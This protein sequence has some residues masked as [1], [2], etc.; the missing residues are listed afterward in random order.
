M[1]CTEKLRNKRIMELKNPPLCKTFGLD[2]L[3]LQTCANGTQA[4]TDFERY[5]V[6]NVWK[7]NIFRKK[8][9]S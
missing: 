8:K 4:L 1:S 9:V 7:T 3:D 6:E 2:K 5:N